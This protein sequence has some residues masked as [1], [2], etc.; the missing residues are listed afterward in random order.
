MEKFQKT[1]EQEIWSSDKY[2]GVVE[3]KDFDGDIVSYKLFFE[4]NAMEAM[5]D[6]QFQ[7]WSASK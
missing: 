5:A 4:Y 6:G 2:V 1:S 3:R 7:N